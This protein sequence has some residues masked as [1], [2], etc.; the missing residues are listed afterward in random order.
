MSKIFRFLTIVLLFYTSVYS[1][2]TITAEQLQKELKLALASREIP[3]KGLWED[4]PN[5]LE[6]FDFSG[7]LTSTISWKSKA[8]IIG[9]D[10]LK[11][12]VPGILLGALVAIFHYN[13]ETTFDRIFIGGAAGG[14]FGGFH[15][16]IVGL[17]LG[18]DRSFRIFQQKKKYYNKKLLL[19]GLGGCLTLKMLCRFFIGMPKGLYEFVGTTFFSLVGAMF[20]LS[21]LIFDEIKY[22]SYSLL[23]A[24]E[25]EGFLKNYLNVKCSMDNQLEM[26]ESLAFEQTSNQDSP[27]YSQPKFPTGLELI[28]KTLKGEDQP[29]FAIISALNASELAYKLED[30]QTLQ[31]DKVAMLNYLN[32]N[33]VDTFWKRVD[34]FFVITGNYGKYLKGKSPNSRFSFPWKKQPGLIAWSNSYDYPL[35]L[36][37]FKGTSEI[38]PD[39]ISD[40]KIPSK[41]LCKLGKVHMGFH[42]IADSCKEELSKKILIACCDMNADAKNVQTIFTGHSMGAAIAAIASINYLAFPLYTKR[43]N[44]NTNIKNSVVVINFGQP[45]IWGKNGLAKFKAALGND[46]LV[47]CVSNNKLDQSDPI[48]GYIKK[49]IDFFGYGHFGHEISLTLPDEERIIRL[50]GIRTIHRLKCYR[51]GLEDYLGSVKSKI[52]IE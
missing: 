43:L 35:I 9:D 37:A 42:D 32:Q 20:G 10:T 15:S 45:K 22:S 34:C 2:S 38:W 47:R 40:A 31:G 17:L 33:I 5:F 25:K 24:E 49:K 12:T 36:V 8:K 50:Y 27:P 51:K 4:L 48:T 13:E 7:V 46:N 11:S 19:S 16:G 29:Y 18:F 39:L 1:S 23:S 6:V 52:V 3:H 26:L 14:L 41:E 44:K 21:A 30:N 28:K